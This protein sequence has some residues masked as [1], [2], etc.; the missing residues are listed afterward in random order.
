MLLRENNN[1]YSTYIKDKLWKEIQILKEKTECQNKNQQKSK[2]LK[3]N[4]I[5]STYSMYSGISVIKSELG[6]YVYSSW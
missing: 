4:N 6:Q 1:Y 3:P 2:A 5:Y